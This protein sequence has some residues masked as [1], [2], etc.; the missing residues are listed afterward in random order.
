MQTHLCR[1]GM[2]LLDGAITSPQSLRI[3]RNEMDLQSH[4]PTFDIPVLGVQQ[5]LKFTNK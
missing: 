4:T 3:I 2:T 1:L 5:L